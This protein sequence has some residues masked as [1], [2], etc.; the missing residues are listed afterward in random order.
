VQSVFLSSKGKDNE[1]IEKIKILCAKNNI[2]C[3]INDVVMSKLTK[4]DNVYAVVCLRN[5]K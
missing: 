4:S 1:G 2:S 3:E 5:M